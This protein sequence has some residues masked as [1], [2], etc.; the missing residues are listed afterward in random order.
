MTALEGQELY[1]HFVHE[2]LR[3]A[4]LG[5]YAVEEE[6]RWSKTFLFETFVKLVGVCQQKSFF[7]IAF[8]SYN[9]VKAYEASYGVLF[10]GKA[11]VSI[12]KTVF[13]HYI[14]VQIC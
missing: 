11:R 10:F 14:R 1:L 8:C 3:Q 6:A 9:E 7:I 13:H 5:D 12:S 4:Q 2:Q